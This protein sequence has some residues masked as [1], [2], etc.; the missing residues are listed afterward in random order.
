MKIPD[1]TLRKKP[2]VLKCPDASTKSQFPN[3]DICNKLRMVCT[4]VTNSKIF[5]EN[6]NTSSQ[7]F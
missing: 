6:I 3:G 2:N 1:K 4:S 7:Y 5:F